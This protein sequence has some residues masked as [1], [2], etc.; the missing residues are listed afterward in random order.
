MSTCLSVSLSISNTHLADSKICKQVSARPRRLPIFL[1]HMF[2]HNNVCDVMDPEAKSA[3]PVGLIYFCKGR[4][5]AK[6]KGKS[7]RVTKA[8]KT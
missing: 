5:D 6:R 8:L 2:Y 3:M 4:T 1:R 7:D